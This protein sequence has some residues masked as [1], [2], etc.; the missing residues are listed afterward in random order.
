MRSLTDPTA[1]N[2]SIVSRLAF[3]LVATGALVAC[4]GT[5]DYRV[6]SSTGSISA[7]FVPNAQARYVFFGRNDGASG[8]LN[9]PGTYN[10]DVGGAVTALGLT[11][12]SGDIAVNDMRGDATFAMGRWSRG[13]VN[14]VNLDTDLTGTDGRSY[15]YLVYNG[16]TAF[17]AASTRTCDAGVFTAPSQA[18]GVTVAD[19]STLGT[20]T[21]AATLV[22][23]SAGARVGV[24]FTTTANGESN[25]ASFA[26]TI[27]DL[28]QY[29]NATG[30]Y[31]AQRAG[32]N[33]VLGNAGNGAVMVGVTYRIGLSNNAIFE[34][35][36]KFRCA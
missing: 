6:V 8:P 15:H 30:D 11:E 26:T 10:Q 5:D 12:I 34:G 9:S 18:S 33:F 27:V 2:H 7:P 29:G 21:G 31:L 36:M 20:T 3:G 35:V 17:P 1:M 22:F 28:A 19:G 14:G 16:L 4:G 24:T 32:A 23:S 25:N 13:H